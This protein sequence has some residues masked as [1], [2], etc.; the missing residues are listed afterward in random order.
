MKTFF[1]LFCARAC[2]Q[3][4]APRASPTPPRVSAG[5]GGY[6]GGCKER[7]GRFRGLPSRVPRDTWEARIDSVWPPCEAPLVPYEYTYKIKGSFI[8]PK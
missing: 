5:A 1:V 7:G 8:Y 3:S 2:T 6:R 4:T